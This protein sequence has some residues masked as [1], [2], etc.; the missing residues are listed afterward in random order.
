MQFVLS[1]W[2]FY[3]WYSQW[4]GY[5]VYCIFF[6]F[7]SC[8]CSCCCCCCVWLW[9][10]T[11]IRYLCAP[12]ACTNALDVYVNILNRIEKYWLEREAKRIDIQTDMLNA[13]TSA[14]KPSIKHNKEQIQHAT[15]FL[16]V[17]FT[18]YLFLFFLHF[19]CCCCCVC[20]TFGCMI[21]I[22]MM[23]IVLSHDMVFRVQWCISA[24]F[25][26]W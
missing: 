16:L 4:I 22:I 13:Y 19:A 2:L 6:Y 20:N 8:R 9:C 21:I 14:L 23:L 15:S 10:Y 17:C 5:N 24:C 11:A 3:T 12:N 7:C 26:H 18:F 1:T 25:Q